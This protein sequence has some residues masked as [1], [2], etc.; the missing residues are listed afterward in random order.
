MRFYTEN[1]RAETEKKMPELL[2]GTVSDYF[3]HPGVAGIDLIDQLKV[4]D[5]IRIEGHTT[6]FE[7][8]VDS[9]QINHANLTEAKA[10]DSVGIRV[11]DRVRP[12]DMVY[13]VT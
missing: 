6:D 7:Q 3:A 10:G 2:V 8:E 5:T 9:I 1:E 4:G 12:G 13:K 11:C